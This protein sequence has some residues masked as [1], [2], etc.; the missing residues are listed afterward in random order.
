M[1]ESRDDGADDEYGSIDVGFDCDK[2]YIDDEAIAETN[3]ENMTERMR[4]ETD[5]PVR[6]CYSR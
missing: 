4:Q 2:R 6:D 5:S 3:F 1:V